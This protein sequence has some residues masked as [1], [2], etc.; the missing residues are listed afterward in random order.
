MHSFRMIGDTLVIE[1]IFRA[2]AD[3]HVT[4]SDF[5]EGG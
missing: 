4:S 5:F 3:M 2:L 1:A